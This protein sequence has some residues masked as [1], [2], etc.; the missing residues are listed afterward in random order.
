[1]IAERWMSVTEA[2]RYL[3]VTT[4][5]I[6]QLLIREQVKGEKLGERSWAVDRVSLSKYSRKPRFGGRPKKRA[7]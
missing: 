1:M 7:S 3:G 5:R 6:R 2:A 4:G